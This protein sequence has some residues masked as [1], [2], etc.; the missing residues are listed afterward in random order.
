MSRCGPPFPADELERVRKERLTTLLQAKDDPADVVPI[1][2]ARTVF[3]AA[4]R[5]GTAGMGT[6]STLKGFTVADLKAFHTAMYQPANATLIVI[7][8]V[9]AADAIAQLEMQFGTWKNWRGTALRDSRCRRRRSSH[10]G[11]SRSSISP[12]LRSRR[13]GSAGSVCRAQR[14][15]TSR[16][17]C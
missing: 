4:H 16:S 17:K 8:D 15:T 3:G 14:R 13:F 7:G 10:R 1:A 5:Y 11:R 12:A 6:E 9:R 2:F